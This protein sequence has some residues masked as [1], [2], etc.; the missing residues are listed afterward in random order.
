MGSI[1]ATADFYAAEYLCGKSAVIDTAQFPFYARE[2]SRIIDKHTFNRIDDRNISDDIKLCC[3]ELAE[4]IYR[5]QKQQD[6]S[7]GVSSESVSGW[8][9]SFTSAEERKTAYNKAVNSIIEKWIAPS[10]RY[11]GLD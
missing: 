3:C 4:Q 1:Y 10:L 11:R 9:K 5:Y 2:A 7:G 6:A 8:S